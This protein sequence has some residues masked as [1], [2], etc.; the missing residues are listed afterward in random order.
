MSIDRNNRSHRPKGLPPQVAGTY[1]PAAPGMD[2]TDVTPPD[3]DGPE[4]DR[5]EREAATLPAPGPGDI[6][7]MLDGHPIPQTVIDRCYGTD[8]IRLQRLVILSHADPATRRELAAHR[9]DHEWVRA[10]ATPLYEDR[11]C[12]IVPASDPWAE[13]DTAPTEPG[14]GPG[15]E[16]RRILDAPAWPHP[17][18]TGRLRDEC[19][20]RIDIMHD[21]QPIRI[22]HDKGVTRITCLD[23]DQ[24]RRRRVF[25]TGDPWGLE[26]GTTIETLGGQDPWHATRTPHAPEP[27]DDDTDQTPDT[28][29]EPDD[30]RRPA[31]R[32]AP[33]AGNTR[34]GRAHGRREAVR[35]ILRFALGLYQGMRIILRR[36]RGRR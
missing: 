3:P 7:W 28:T 36:A 17:I 27:A 2:T 10:H 22:S 14:D 19:S 25:E 34:A 16:E 15:A 32:P 35:A 11:A 24:R 4:L 20:A 18:D 8:D 29:P 1:E 13:D 26:D 21:Y 31:R 30:T 9:D 5:L 6:A 12:I 23:L 33:P